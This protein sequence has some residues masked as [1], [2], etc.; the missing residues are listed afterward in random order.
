MCFV[1]Q[2]IQCGG[3]VVEVL[4]LNAND[5]EVVAEQASTKPAASTRSRRTTRAMA[6]TQVDDAPAKKPAPRS[7][8]KKSSVKP[9]KKVR[10]VVIRLRGKADEWTLEEGVCETLIVGS[11]KPSGKSRGKGHFLELAVAGVE[12]NHARLDLNI[13]NG[14]VMVKVTD[15]KSGAQ[16]F[17]DK[18]LIAKGM[19]S[20]AFAG[21]D[22][23]IGDAVLEIRKK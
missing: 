6:A 4:T 2:D 3:T 20:M 7:S 19:N 16:T 15:L 1:N 14:V 8:T 5:M 18:K 9:S 22:I 21:D 12:P 17:H 11:S 13:N 10:S 23:Q